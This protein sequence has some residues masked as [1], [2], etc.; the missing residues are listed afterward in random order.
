MPTI[1]GTKADK[2]YLQQRIP[3]F[4]IQPNLRGIDTITG[5]NK[6]NRGP[7]GALT[8]TLSR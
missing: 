6:F 1:K 7:S 3:L 5:C 2:N 8:T 4:S